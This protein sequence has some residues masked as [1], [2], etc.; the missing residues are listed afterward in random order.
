LE[1]AKEMVV[2]SSEK[3]LLERDVQRN[4]GEELLNAIRDV[5]AGRQGA[6]YTV[7]PNEIMATRVKCGLSQ[8]QFA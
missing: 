3:E 4:I 6:E 2:P 5:K 7:E 8:T 1:G